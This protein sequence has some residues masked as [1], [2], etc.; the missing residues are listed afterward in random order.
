MTF[1]IEID[2]FLRKLNPKSKVAQIF[3]TAND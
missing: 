1:T 3:F 2:K